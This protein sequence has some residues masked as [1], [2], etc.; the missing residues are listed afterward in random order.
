[1]EWTPTDAWNRIL[2][3]AKAGIPEQSFRTWLAGLS[4]AG[5]DADGSLL[6]ETPSDF[7]TE[8]VEDKFGPGLQD[9]A[10]RVLGR[11]LPLKFRTTDGPVT[12][13]PNPDWTLDTGAS[14][15]HGSPI[16][17]VRPAPPP[18][19]SAGG[20]TSG[21]W[22]SGSTSGYASGYTSGSNAGPRSGLQRTPSAPDALSRPMSAAEAGL[23]ERYT[24]ERF[25]VGTNNQL[26][27]AASHAVAEIPARVYNPLFIYG[28]VGLGKTHLMHAVG[29]EV[30]KRWPERR[31]AYV[32]AERFTNEMVMAIQTASTAEFR[33]RYRQI[34]LLLVDDVQFIGDKRGTQEEFFHTFNSLYDAGKQIILTSDRPPKDLE[35]MEDRLVSR[36]EWGLVVDI[37]PPDYETRM[38][39]L[40]KKAEDDRLTLDDDV[41]EFIARSCTA[42][43]REL[44]GAVI[45]LLAFSSLTR[46]EVSVE[47]AR[48]ALQGLL[49]QG[50]V[51]EGGRVSADTIRARVADAWGVTADALIS[52][53]R[54]R[55]L[56]VPR[57]VAMYLI[58]E[59]VDSSLV[60]IGRGFGGRDHST[61]I[62]SIR[63]VEED[64]TQ[65]PEFA[66]RVDLVR[67]S[68][69]GS[70]G[71]AG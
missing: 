45:K 27:A 69:Q 35:A 61:V 24:F 58:R 14:P 11:P 43:V 12:G 6:I 44:E 37:K 42:S 66:R 18:G 46:S 20:N 4:V 55:D 47:L 17:G 5:L 2:D 38:A 9:L 41:I 65:N 63:K 29:H 3:A 39:I 49:R 7:H 50:G 16:P 8:W 56:T 53:R 19:A 15:S 71:G 32:S 52:K 25:V 54:T 28:G 40:R 30:L 13:A 1:M 57:Q 33:R 10:D 34:D 68:L 23:N 26:A 22:G 21:G 31:V 59:L 36:F 64:L 48:T 62:H 60:T 70:G 67:R 51:P